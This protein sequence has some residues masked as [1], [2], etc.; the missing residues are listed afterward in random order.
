MSAAQ[1][2]AALPHTNATFVKLDPRTCFPHI[3]NIHQFSSTAAMTDTSGAKADYVE[4]ANAPKPTFSETRPEYIY[5]KAVTHPAIRFGRPRKYEIESKDGMI[6]ER[7][8]K[9]P[10]RGGVHVWCDIFKPEKDM[11]KLAPLIAWTV[12]SSSDEIC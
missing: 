12:P 5:R 3:T 7:D 4:D 11:G 6:I 2:T 10:V 8:V 1:S 9:V